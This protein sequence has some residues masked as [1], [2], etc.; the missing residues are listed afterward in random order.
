MLEWIGEHEALL[1]WTGWGSLLLFVID[2]IALPIFVVA[3]P[4]DY[5][6]G[7][8]P[9]R[10]QWSARRPILYQLARILKN[11]AGIL[12][13]VLGLVMLALPGQGLLTMLMGAVLLEFPGK[14][15]WEQR[16]ARRPRVRR[17]L[18][19]IRSRAGREELRMEPS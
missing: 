14:R 17:A 8:R 6:L 18:D 16:L 11:A 1:V 19:W 13:V 4:R 5:F 2:L 9:P 7:P 10:P 3:L 15:R 12:L